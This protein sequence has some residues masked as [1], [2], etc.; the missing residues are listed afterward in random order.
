MGGIS[1]NFVWKSLEVEG[2][3]FRNIILLSVFSAISAI[4]PLQG[5]S[6]AHL[7]NIFWRVVD[8]PIFYKTGRTQSNL[9]PKGVEGAFLK[10][11]P[12]PA[13]ES[14]SL[15]SWSLSYG[16]S[17]APFFL[18]VEEEDVVRIAKA[19]LRAS[20]VQRKEIRL[21]SIPAWLHSCLQKIP[22]GLP[23]GHWP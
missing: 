4:L 23:S 10:Y 9:R 7:I 12:D 14:P 5:A 13:S 6:L 18:A 16:L 15:K 17:L 2:K 20:L 11:G 8:S 21:R 3:I 22:R 1:G 19:L